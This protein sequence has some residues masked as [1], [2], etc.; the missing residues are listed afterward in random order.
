MRLWNHNPSGFVVFLSISSQYGGERIHQLVEDVPGYEYD[1]IASTT[2]WT[3][4][5]LRRPDLLRCLRL[6]VAEEKRGGYPYEFRGFGI[7]GP[8]SAEAALLAFETHR[9]SPMMMWQTHLFIKR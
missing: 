1:G 5:D 4:F 2:G 6:Y 9:T 7:G 8:E 3:H